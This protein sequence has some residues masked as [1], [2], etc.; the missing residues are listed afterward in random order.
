MRVRVIVQERVRD[1]ETER[2]TDR[3]GR[4]E[5]ERFVDGGGEGKESVTRT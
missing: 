1:T 4:A 3:E 2:Q 5:K